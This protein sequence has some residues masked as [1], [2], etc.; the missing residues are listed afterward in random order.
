MVKALLLFLWND[1]NSYSVFSIPV[2]TFPDWFFESCT[3]VLLSSFSYALPKNH[4]RKLFITFV[5][6]K[7][8]KQD[9]ILLL[10]NLLE[11]L[12]HFSPSQLLHISV[13][14]TKLQIE[15]CYLNLDLILVAR[16][17]VDLGA[18]FIVREYFTFLYFFSLNQRH[19][20]FRTDSVAQFLFFWISFYEWLKINWFL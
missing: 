12:L 15:R 9:S 13:L 20:S 18:S 2:C 16:G 10:T 6:N 4:F 17:N 1:C 3:S 19:T 8:K 5:V 7:W 11:N 14:L